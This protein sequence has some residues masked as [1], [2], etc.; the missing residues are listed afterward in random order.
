MNYKMAKRFK[1]KPVHLIVGFIIVLFILNQSGREETVP[2]VSDSDGNDYYS[3]G[4]VT[5]TGGQEVLDYCYSPNH[6][7]E[8]KCVNGLREAEIYVC[9]GTSCNDGACVS[10]DGNGGD[11]TGECLTDTE[12]PETQYCWFDASPSICRTKITTGSTQLCDRNRQCVSNFC[13][14]DPGLVH[15]MCTEPPEDEPTCTDLCQNPGDTS[16]V[17]NAVAYCNY[18]NNEQCLKWGALVDCGS[19]DCQD[20]EC[21]VEGGW[22]QDTEDLDASGPVKNYGEEG[23]VSSSNNV[24]FKDKC[25][26]DNTLKEYFCVSSTSTTI[27]SET[28][29]CDCSGLFGRCL[30][31]TNGNGNGDNGV[32]GDC[33]APVGVDWGSWLLKVENEGSLEECI[34]AGCPYI[35]TSESVLLKLTDIIPFTAS[36]NSLQCC[37]DTSHPVKE[38]T[39]S[40]LLGA[41]KVEHGICVEGASFIYN[42]P[43]IVDD[44]TINAIIW[45]GIAMFAFMFMMNMFPRN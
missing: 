3:K 17:G 1:L 25:T 21:I 38:G 22:C 29:T 6:V 35:D 30:D 45:A 28:K 43:K 12:C 42:L 39:V 32:T 34:P 23:V 41:V 36:S 20:G 44:V 4:F 40:F 2:C 26:D 7:M 8:Q 10:I 37:V 18:Y 16:C 13:N 15:P 11:G 9:Q 14:E 19:L 33:P 27:S 5:L 24:A 31:D